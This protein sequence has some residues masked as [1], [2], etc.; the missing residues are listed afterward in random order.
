MLPLSRRERDGPM[1]RH[2][3]SEGPLPR[4]EAAF[5]LGIGTW[6]LRP[7]LRR[8]Q[9][10]RDAAV[11]HRLRSRSSKRRLNQDRRR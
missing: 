1:V 8:F 3:H 11:L 5:H 9:R 6:Q 7:L 4:L 2:E 10:G